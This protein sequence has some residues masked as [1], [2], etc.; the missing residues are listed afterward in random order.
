MSV[1]CNEYCASSTTQMRIAAPPQ[2]PHRMCSSLQQYYV[3]LPARTEGDAGKEATESPPARSVPI[4][5]SSRT[6]A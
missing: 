4:V 3:L 6:R 2:T 5:F 1:I